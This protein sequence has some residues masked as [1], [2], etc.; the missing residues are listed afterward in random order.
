M[1][2]VGEGL[3]PTKGNMLAKGITIGCNSLPYPH[4]PDSR[5]RTNTG[6]LYLPSALVFDRL[7]L[8][9]ESYK[10]PSIALNVG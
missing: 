8:R 10:M 3:L 2:Q 6:F 9:T 7:R 1:L 5:R 4:M